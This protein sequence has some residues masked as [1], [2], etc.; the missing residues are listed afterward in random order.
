MGSRSPE[1]TRPSV[2]WPLAAI[3]VPIVSLIAKIRISDE[4]ALGKLMDYKAYEK[5]CAEEGH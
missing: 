4:A 1:S 3:I 5:Q 2:F